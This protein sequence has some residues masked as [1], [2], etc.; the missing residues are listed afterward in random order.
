MFALRMSILPSN[1]LRGVRSRGESCASAVMPIVMAIAE[2]RAPREIM[3]VLEALQFNGD[4]PQLSS[5]ARI[6]LRDVQ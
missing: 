2:A 6:L 5:W 4:S 3:R 1:A